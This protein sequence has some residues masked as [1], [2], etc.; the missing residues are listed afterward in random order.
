M[1]QTQQT[2]PPWGLLAILL[3]GTMMGTLGNS[4]VSIALP[5]LREHFSVSLSSAVW[6]ITLYTLTFSVLMP[7]FSAIGPAIGLKRMYIGSMGLV[8]LGSLISV[9]APNFFVFLVA[10][11]MTGIGVGTFLP[12]IMWV[13]ANR[14][15]VEYQG[16]ATGYWALVNSL[17]HAIGPTLGGFFLQFTGWQ[18]IFLINIPLGLLSIV[19]AIK[20]FLRVPRTAIQ[21]FDTAGA[22]A[23]VV[24]TF[25]TMLAITMT[26]KNGFTFLPAILLWLGSIMSF[27]FI[28]IYER[29]R[30]SPFVDLSLFTNKQYLAAV[31]SI[32]T[33][34]FSQ[35][36]LLVAL[37]VFLIDIHN[38]NNQIA[39]LLVMVMTMTMSILSPVSGRLSDRLGSKLIC[40]IGVG[41]IAL[42]GAYFLFVR[43]GVSSASDW[44][45]FIVGLIIFG[46]GFG[47]VQSAS[48]VSVI[49]SVPA[50]KN[51]A[52]TGFFHM[53]RF[54]VASLG[55]TVIGIILELN[56]GGMLSG[57]YQGF[58][59][60]LLVALITLPSTAWMVN[61]KSIPI[62]D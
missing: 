36:G 29:K 37:P 10:R 16:Q 11:V 34:A 51:S 7:V 4:M 1:N 27:V 56:A 50:D 52:A 40:F 41:M 59:V 39:G 53:I 5:M 58:M 44:I 2:T 13:I 8:C 12:A 57:Y 49:Q 47:F 45:L 18:W 15:P 38:V 25:C 43:T 60:I 55:S 6:S 14:F 32:A 46:I 26:A 20:L 23:V 54:I 33:Q 42:G 48:T 35:F 28:L 61:K 31:F 17:G 24:L 19:L 9:L 62:S 21:R 30:T 22:V 3:I